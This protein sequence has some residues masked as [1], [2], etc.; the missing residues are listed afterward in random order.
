MNCAVDCIISVIS[1]NESILNNIADDIKINK[2]GSNEKEKEKPLFKSMQSFID[3]AKEKEVLNFFL[4][5]F[6]KFVLFFSS[7]E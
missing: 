6:L 2:G 4:V 1:N 7:K 5:N 3:F